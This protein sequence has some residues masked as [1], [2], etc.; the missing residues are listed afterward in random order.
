MLLGLRFSICQLDKVW[1]KHEGNSIAP[2]NLA[3]ISSNGLRIITESGHGWNVF[4]RD[5][6]Y[7][8]LPDSDDVC[9][10][11]YGEFS[12]CL[13]E[14]F[15]TDED[16]V[17]D[18]EDQCPGTTEGTN[19]DDTGCAMNQLDSDGDGISDATDQCPNTL[20]EIVLD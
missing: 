4:E 19:V 16:G 2:A 11:I 12:G 1:V 18:K 13:E 9:P 5:R 7:D 17:N 8:G 6:D 15:D 20:V 14:F 3:L 10:T